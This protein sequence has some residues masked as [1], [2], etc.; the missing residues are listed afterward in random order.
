[1]KQSKFK[2]VKNIFID[3]VDTE[4]YVELDSMRYNYEV[5][6]ESL[7]KP[8]KMI[9]LFGKPGTGKSMTLNK[10]YFNLKNSREI[11]YFDAPILSEKA[12]LKSI[13]NNN[14]IKQLIKDGKPKKA[15]NYIITILKDWK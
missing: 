5:L 11:H 4:S 2:D 9:L 12:F 3:T 6:E 1:M 15:E 10:L 8:L 7:K 13:S 14:E